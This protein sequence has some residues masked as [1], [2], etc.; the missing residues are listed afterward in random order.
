MCNYMLKRYLKIDLPKGQSLFLWGARKTGKSTYLKTVF[1]KS[2]YIDFLDHD[3]FL[4]YS[5]RPKTL[6]EYIETLSQEQLNCP[7]I[8]DEVQKVPEILDEVHWLIENK[9]GIAFILCG[10]S[11]RKLKHA[12]SNLLGGRAWRH[13]F[14]PLC[15]P[16]LPS[17]DLIKILN[18]GL[19]PSHYLAEKQYFKLLK[20]YVSDYLIPEVQWESRIR[21]MGSFNRFLEAMAYSNGEMLNYSNIAREC[22]VNTRT[23][24]LYVDLLVDMLLAYRVFPYAK[25]KKRQ[26]ITHIPKFYFFDPGIVNELTGRKFITIKGAEIGHLFEQYVLLELIAYKELNDKSF[27]ISYWRTK[28]GLELDFVI[29]KAEIGIEVKISSH[30]ERRDIK[31]LIEFGKEYTP[32]KLYVVCL[33]SIPRIMKLDDIEIN[34]MPLELFLKELWNGKIITETNV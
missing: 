24:Q 18:Q 1:E 13:L 26:I 23:V 25:S 30:I 29:G 21:Q 32:N 5:R 15:Y 10:S 31:G 3:T 12:G 27:E 14:F 9:K 11:I 4:Q 19:I 16:E 6:R 2:V 17:F 20:G 33:E 22:A 8:L 34:I 7:L 28:N